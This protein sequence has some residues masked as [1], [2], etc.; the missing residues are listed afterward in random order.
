MKGETERPLKT[1]DV[2]Q[3]D[4]AVFA[5]IEEELVYEFEDA[6]KEDDDFFK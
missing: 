4:G 2:K 6:E 3:E 5:N 1:Y